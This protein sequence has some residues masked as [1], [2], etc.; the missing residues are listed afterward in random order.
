MRYWLSFD[1]GLRGNYENLYNWLDNCDA[2]ECG[3]NIASFSTKKTRGEIKE[4]LENI[5]DGK[6]RIYIIGRNELGKF[7]GRFILGSRKQAP[8]AGFA[9]KEG[10]IDEGEET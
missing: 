2:V 3:D 10:E 1:L 9:T 4:E 7:V 6:A 8:W 5:L